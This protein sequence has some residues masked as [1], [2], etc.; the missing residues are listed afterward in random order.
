VDVDAGKLTRMLAARMAAI[1]PP[2]FDVQADAG[3]LWYSCEEGRFP[4]QSGDYHVGRSGTF[5]EANLE[6]HGQPEEDAITAV[7]ALALGELR[8][9]VDE[10]THDPWPVRRGM[11]PQ[12]RAQVRGQMLHMWYG[13][14]DISA[15]V[16]VCEPVPLSDL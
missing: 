15:P 5:V 4:G 12:P 16:L 1:V 9:Y 3:M 2:G 14:P 7:A 11:P 8:D 13:G 10:A 6:G